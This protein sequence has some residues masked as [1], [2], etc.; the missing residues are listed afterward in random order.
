MSAYCIGSRHYSIPF[1]KQLRGRSATNN[2]SNKRVIP[3][4]VF[5]I[6]IWSPL[7]Y[8]YIY[9]VENHIKIDDLG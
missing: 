9:I 6:W 1:P 8:L 5:Y 4:N 2:A 3:K 7:F